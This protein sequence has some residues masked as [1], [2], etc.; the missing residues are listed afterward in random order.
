MFEENKKL[1]YELKDK[2]TRIWLIRMIISKKPVPPD[3]HLQEP[4]RQ[5][6]HLHEAGPFG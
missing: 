3:D 2:W 6:E 5:D 1:A 4:V